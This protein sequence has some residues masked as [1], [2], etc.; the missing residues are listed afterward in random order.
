MSISRET[1]DPAKN[2]K[3][4]RYHQDTDLLRL[5]GE[6]GPLQGGDDRQQPGLPAD[7]HAL[8]D[9]ELTEGAA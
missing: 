6:Q 5:D 7:S 8:G 9:A 3:R 1:F 2:Y 4:I